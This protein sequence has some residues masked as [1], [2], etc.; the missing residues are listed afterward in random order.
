M[1]GSNLAMGAAVGE[2]EVWWRVFRS[3]GV[4]NI[5]VQE[6]TDAVIHAVTSR[7][8]LRKGFDGGSRNSFSTASAGAGHARI[9]IFYI[10]R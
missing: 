1:Y 6:L 5:G 7:L 10:G 4:F 8:Q 3:S 2:G 9:G